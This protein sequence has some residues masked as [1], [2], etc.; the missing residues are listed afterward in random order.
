VTAVPDPYAAPAPLPAYA[1]QAPKDLT[2]FGVLAFATAAASTVLTAA[3]ASLAGSAARHADADDELDWTFALFGLGSILTVLALV[4]GWV[5]ASLWLHRARKNAEALNPAFEHKRS[6]GWAWGGWVC[7]IVS[8]WF[9]FQV[10]RDVHRSV[11]PT[12]TTSVIGWWWALFVTYLVV[13]RFTGRIDVDA[14]HAEGLQSAW[15]FLTVV[16]V[17]ALVLWGLVL[18]TVTRE[19]HQRMYAGPVAAA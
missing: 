9:P 8:F 19:Q 12:S 13:D 10:V 18:R 7:P 17:A 3:T 16:M 4:A 5:T 14:R 11:S 1:P 6:A 15:V 2:A